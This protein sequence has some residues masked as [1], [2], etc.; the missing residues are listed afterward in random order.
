MSQI[1]G[2][3]L[4]GR[5]W[6]IHLCRKVG[7]LSPLKIMSLLKATESRLVC[8][9]RML[10]IAWL[11][12]SCSYVQIG[13][14]LNILTDPIFRYVLLSTNASDYL[15]SP[16]LGEKRLRPAP[17]SLEDITKLDIILVSH[18]HFDHLGISPH[19]A[20]RTE[21]ASVRQIGNSARWYIPLG[22]KKWFNRRGI[23]NVVEMKWWQESAIPG[24]PEYMVVATPAMVHPLT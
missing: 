22:L 10:K 13:N 7:L 17:L 9:Y 6:D 16:L 2:C 21:D 1:W 8:H 18:N 4:E 5:T 24:H 3:C 12:Q 19:A 20:N 15:I 11:G 23:T 14:S